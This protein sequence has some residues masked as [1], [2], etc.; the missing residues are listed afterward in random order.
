MSC[1]T[2]PPE[3]KNG[4]VSYESLDTGGAW[5]DNSDAIYKCYKYYG[6]VDNHK[7]T[8]SSGS[9]IGTLPKCEYHI[10]TEGK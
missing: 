6:L 3:V 5:A 1:S 4:Y 9:W 10:W 8:C 2:A 7:Q